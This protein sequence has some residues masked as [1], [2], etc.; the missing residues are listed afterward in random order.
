M[1]RFLQRFLRQQRGAS[2]L[3]F[4]LVAPL[5]LVLLAGV[6]DFGLLVQSRSSMEAATSSA[7]SYALAKAQDIKPDTA[8]SYVKTIADIAARQL[9][10][11]VTVDVALN[12]SLVAGAS[13]SGPHQSGAGAVANLCYCPTRSGNSLTW[14]N[15]AACGAPC[16]DGGYAGKFLAIKASKP[17]QALFF[18][19]GLARDGV[20][21]VETLAGL[22]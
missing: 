6:V 12:R 8:V 19:F 11:G 10:D 1:R 18:E 5:V 13:A 9:G 2:A 7:M 15:S 20:L 21:T 14:G 16:P 3:E 17:Y 22:Q 4:A